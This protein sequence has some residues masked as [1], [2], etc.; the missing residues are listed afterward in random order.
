MF[1]VVARAL[2][3]G[4]YGHLNATMELLKEVAMVPWVVATVASKQDVCLL[5]QAILPILL[6]DR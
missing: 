3:G 2:L 1:C 6:S 4:F 5:V